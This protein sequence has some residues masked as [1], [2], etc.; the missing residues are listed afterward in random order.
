MISQKIINKAALPTYEVPVTQPLQRFCALIGNAEKRNHHPGRLPSDRCRAFA[1][2][3]H[4]PCT[5]CAKA[6]HENESG[7][8]GHQRDCKATAGSLGQFEHIAPL[9]G[10][11]GDGVGLGILVKRGILGI[12]I[13]R[14]IILL[15]L[16]EEVEFH[17][18]LVPVLIAL[19]TDEPVV[20]ALGL[21]GH[22]DIVAG[23][24]FKI[25]GVVQSQATSLINWK[26]SI[27]LA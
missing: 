4:H 1:Q 23:L 26:A 6:P 21:A 3:V 25:A 24:G 18:R 27:Y 15:A 22:R 20:G 13:D 12:G 7:L 8:S 19:A 16:V 2:S 17:H 5:D 10:L 9:H 11:L 14:A